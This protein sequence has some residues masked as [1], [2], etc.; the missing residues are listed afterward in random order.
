[1]ETVHQ[2]A[3][4]YLN[5]IDLNKIRIL[6]CNRIS[7]KSSKWNT[8]EHSH[9]Y[10]E[11]IYF[12]KGQANIHVGDFSI[13]TSIYDVIVYLPGQVHQETVDLTKEQ[14]V[15]CI[16][17]DT[18]TKVVT[19]NNTFKLC[20]HSGVLRWLFEQ[21][22]IEYG[23]GNK[24]NSHLSKI[25]GQ[26]IILQ[27]IKYLSA[28]ELSSE[29]VI[30]ERIK[31]YIQHNISNNITPPQLAAMCNI[32]RSYL[33]RLFRM[34]LKTTPAHY[35]NHTRITVAQNLLATTDY[36]IQR[37]AHSIGF[38]DAA[39]FSRVFKELAGVTPSQFR[40]SCNLK[41]LT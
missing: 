35:I 39:Y 20:D 15:I 19:H 24:V 1:M 36:S 34:H 6:N 27:F 30:L 7:Q 37:I 10:M 40:L 8:N 23:L 32:S 26:A 16:G 11:M 14:K 18:N 29:T 31:D 13:H 25:Y 21:V 2:E 38:N 22:C 33:H 5:S 9:T 3:L 12:L 4:L 41:K 17:I 28:N